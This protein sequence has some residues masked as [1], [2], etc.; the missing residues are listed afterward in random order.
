MAGL[1]ERIELQKAKGNEDAAFD[2]AG[3]HVVVEQTLHRAARNFREAVAFCQEPIFERLAAIREARQEVA[4][5]KRQSVLQAF[6][7]G[8]LRAC[9]EGDDVDIDVVSRKR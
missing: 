3:R 7:R 5:I 4:A 2:G 8:Q 6:G 9:L 1:V